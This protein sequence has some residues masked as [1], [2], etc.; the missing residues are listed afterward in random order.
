MEKY[1][2]ASEEERSLRFEPLE[3]K[4]IYKMCFDRHQ[5]DLSISTAVVTVLTV[6]AVGMGLAYHTD[7][8]VDFWN[9][10]RILFTDYCDSFDWCNIIQLLSDPFFME[11]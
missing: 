10:K 9:R 3:M 2:L 6:I 8:F 5:N 1:Q 7:L 11:R 4:H